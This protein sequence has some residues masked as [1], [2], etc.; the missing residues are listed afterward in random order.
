MYHYLF[1]TLSFLFLYNIFSLNLFFFLYLFSVVSFKIFLFLCKTFSLSYSL[2]FPLNRTFLIFSFKSR[3]LTLL[4]SLEYS[5][6]ILF[7]YFVSLSRM[8]IF[9]SL[10]FVLKNKTLHFWRSLYV[11]S[12]KSQDHVLTIKNIY[13]KGVVG[14]VW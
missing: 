1:Q 5:T 2:T 14:N 12:L 4:C 8:K 6:L 13:L 10:Y 9:D 7:I 11:F 3:S